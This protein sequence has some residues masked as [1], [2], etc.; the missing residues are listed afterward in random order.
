MAILNVR[1]FGCCHCGESFDCISSSILSDVRH[2]PAIPQLKNE[3]GEQ[4]VHQNE[5][6]RTDRNTSAGALCASYNSSPGSGGGHSAERP[7]SFTGIAASR[8]NNT[9]FDDNRDSVT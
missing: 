7:K 5:E 8:K 4:I 9:Y 6:S 3:R 2:S 1:E